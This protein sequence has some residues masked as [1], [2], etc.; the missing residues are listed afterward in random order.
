MKIKLVLPWAVLVAY[1]LT[2]LV[3][4]EDGQGPVVLWLPLLAAA[5][6][7]NITRGGPIIPQAIIAV[8]CGILGCISIVLFAIMLWRSKWAA[9]AACIALLISEVAFIAGTHP[10]AFTAASAVPFLILSTIFL[11]RELAA[12]IMVAVS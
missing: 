3:W 9:L 5:T 4:G 7:G 2:W 11:R 10:R 6:F 12:H 1:L 8:M